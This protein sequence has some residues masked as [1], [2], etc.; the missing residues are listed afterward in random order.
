M[1]DNNK[2]GSGVGL[3]QRWGKPAL[4]LLLLAAAFLVSCG[5]GPTAKPS[6]GVM[7]LS[8]PSKTGVGRSDVVSTAEP[9]E[10]V[11]CIDPGHGFEDGGCT[12]EY[13]DGLNEKDISLAISLMLDEELRRLG[14]QTVLTHDGQTF[15][16][17]SVDNDNNK[18]SVQERTAYANGLDIDY[19]ISL[20][21]NSFEDGSVNGTQIYYYD[22]SV[23][24]EH[25]SGAIADAIRSSLLSTMG[26]E[27]SVTAVEMTTD[28]YYVIRETTVPACLIEMG[29]VTN[30]T[31]AADLMD[32]TWQRNFAKGVAAGID[33]Y[34]RA[35]S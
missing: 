33:R 7:R 3:L 20:H 19:Y 13:L 4:C 1:N 28:A 29:F 32:G 21:C 16:V 23:K 22:G 31:D 34:Y 9:M 12:S 25:T 30:E 26:T 2:H 10:Q 17:T 6:V 15:P 24:T 18:F 35:G 11:I 8:G 14:Y 27:R 5:N